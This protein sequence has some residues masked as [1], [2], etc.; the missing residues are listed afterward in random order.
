M[1]KAA[2][3]EYDLL[4]AGKH[5]IGR[6][7]QTSPINPKPKA[8]AMQTPAH[9]NLRLAARLR[10]SGHALAHEIGNVFEGH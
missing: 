1:P 2:V 7:G 10:N 8:H 4:M 5:D 3:D 6:P 9:R